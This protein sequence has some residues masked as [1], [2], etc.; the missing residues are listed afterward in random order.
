MGMI[1]SDCIEGVRESHRSA[2]VSHKTLGK[3]E[4]SPSTYFAHQLPE[5]EDHR[6]TSR[7]MKHLKEPDV[8]I[9]SWCLWLST[10]HVFFP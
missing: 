2:S 8:Y 10:P 9:Q 7:K 4:T 1:Q 5:I 3:T 6:T